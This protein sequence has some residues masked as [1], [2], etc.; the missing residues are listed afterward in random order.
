MLL[1]NYLVS[2]TSARASDDPKFAQES[3]YVAD[4]SWPHVTRV[5]VDDDQ[6]VSSTTGRRTHVSNLTNRS[7]DF[8][9]MAG[10]SKKTKVIRFLYVNLRPAT[11][12]CGIVA[13]SIECLF[14]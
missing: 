14:S 10:I 5:L 8:V 13:V 4:Q 12:C 6:K 9:D 2:K 7:A 1:H 3:A 11:V